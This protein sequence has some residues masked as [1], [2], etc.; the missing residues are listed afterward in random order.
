M[1][2]SS[3]STPSA[4]SKILDRY[5][6]KADAGGASHSEHEENWRAFFA[7]KLKKFGVDS[8]QKLSDADKKKF[9]TEIEN[10]W[11]AK[12]EPGPPGKQ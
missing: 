7:G 3:S 9:Y 10:E 11:S 1:A 8:P 2:T 5:R 6:R 4:I 12:D